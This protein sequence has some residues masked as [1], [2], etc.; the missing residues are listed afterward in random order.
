[1]QK[2]RCITLLLGILGI[3]AGLFCLSWFFSLNKGPVSAAETMVQTYDLV[4]KH[5]QIL[6]GTGEKAVF[7][8]D[9]AIKEGKI[10]KVGYVTEKE[11]KGL[12][13][14][15]VFDAGGLTVM[16]FP[17]SQL[18]TK[19]VVEHLFRTSYPRYPAHYL[20]FQ[21]GDYAMRSLLQ[22][23]KQRGE[24]PEKTFAA[25]C[26]QL[27]V[28]TKVY[29]LPLEMDE[30]KLDEGSYPVEQLVA[31]QTGDLA[32]AMGA[33]DVGRI[34][35]GCTADLYFFIAHHYDEKALQEV[36]LKG[37]LPTLA[38]SCKEGKLSRQ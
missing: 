26:G 15:P 24:T 12:K 35:E 14:V 2:K 22:V 18:H 29:L 4:I 25:L 5:A 23:A 32:L 19:E 28:N 10:A 7:R 1:M 34:K 36:L 16:P 20:F 30:N 38:I 17:L 6:D 8:G 27:P 37:E 13:K 33:K 3:G 11:L 21:E 31:F 9:I